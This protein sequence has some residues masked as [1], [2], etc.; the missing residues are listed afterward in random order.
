MD[1]LTNWEQRP[2]GDMRVGL[3]AIEDLADRLGNPHRGYPIVH[4]TGTKGKGS[5]CAL[6]EAGLLRAGLSVGRYGSPHV[7]RVNERISLNGATIDN[8]TLGVA[9]NA[10]LRAHSAAVE[11]G[12]LG[13]HATWFDLMTI[14]AYLTFAQ[15]CIDVA[16]VETGLGGRLDSTNIARADVA[17]ITNVH[18]EHTEVLGNTRSAIAFEKA[19]IIKPASVVVTTLASDDEAGSIVHAR[20]HSLGCRLF[21]AEVDAGQTIADRNRSVACTTLDALGS[22]LPRLSVGGWLID[23][24]TANSVRLPGR[25]EAFTE[26]F[27]ARDRLTSVPVI[28]DGAHVPFNLAAVLQDLQVRPECSTRPVV[29]ISIASDKDADG[30]LATLA[31]IC[32]TLVVGTI[33]NRSS[34]PLSDLQGICAELN[35]SFV[36]QENPQAAYQKAVEAAAELNSWVLVTGSLHLAGALQSPYRSN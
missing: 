26:R 9:L 22:A 30:L 19:G 4:V 32:P 21:L 15:S 5:T 2:R 7:H 1:E 6:I 33:V 23:K 36:A 34:R 20:A 16:V 27:R 17:V 8:T 12:T 28:V 24:D 10:A 31:V 29:V 14:A 13:R 35:I 18:L 3:S 25:L 11:D